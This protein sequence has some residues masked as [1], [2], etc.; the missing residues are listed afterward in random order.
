M[1]L[2]SI[3]QMAFNEEI[4]LD[5]SEVLEATYAAPCVTFTPV[6]SDDEWPAEYQTWDGISNSVGNRPPT[7]GLLS[8]EN[9]TDSGSRVVGTE[10][11]GKER[12]ESLGENHPKV[13]GQ[14]G[15]ERH[16]E[17][18]EKE[19][20][21]ERS[22][23]VSSGKKVEEK[24]MKGAEREDNRWT[25]TVNKNE[26][27]AARRKEGMNS[28]RKGRESEENKK[29]DRSGAKRK[30]EREESE[31]D[32]ERKGL[33]VEKE[34]GAP[35][36]TREVS[37]RP[38]RTNTAPT[39][40]PDP[41]EEVTTRKHNRTKVTS[42]R[43]KRTGKGKAECSS[44]RSKNGMTADQSPSDR[45]GPLRLK[46]INIKD[47]KKKTTAS[48][49]V[50]RPSVVV[51]LR[52][53]E[54]L[55]VLPSRKVGG[56][57]EEDKTTASSKRGGDKTHEEGV[58]AASK[59][60]EEETEFIILDEL[61]SDSDTGEKDEDNNRGT[62]DGPDIAESGSEGENAVEEESHRAASGPGTEEEQKTEVRTETREEQEQELC[63]LVREKE[64]D[65][66]PARREETEK[67]REGVWPMKSGPA[68]QSQDV[69]TE[70]TGTDQSG[71]GENQ[72]KG[73]LA[74]SGA[75]KEEATE[76]KKEDEKQ[77]NRQQAAQP[78]EE[79][80]RGGGA[81]S[82]EGV[83]VISSHEE[84][85]REKEI[86]KLTLDEY[87]SKYKNEDRQRPLKMSYC[88]AAPR[89]TRKWDP[90]GATVPA[91]SSSPPRHSS[92]GE[93]RDVGEKKSE[94]THG[95]SRR[96]G[97]L[98]PGLA[99]ASKSVPGPSRDG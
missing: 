15:A 11:G 63:H 70:K 17:R 10:S 85:G 22:S 87:K 42:G 59:A 86:K 33:R 84:V 47:E 99:A 50:G 72:T 23:S 27:T 62:L 1:T 28:E 25:R 46:A 74:E 12:E 29:R 77:S 79:Q 45:P 34:K 40:L 2:S 14:E 88:L 35:R 71:G 66:A 93:P 69:N 97:G 92:S 43:C 7:Q 95:L 24:K 52:L 90:E 30:H 44:D 60:R 4:E 16:K 56:T 38:S 39:P 26:H 96:G 65:E 57:G 18:K 75:E 61:S 6:Y 13:P 68:Q 76:R 94:V 82:V 98:E 3:V 31:G 58:K 37:T 55:E 41:E 32:G 49:T 78:Q 53:P 89:D 19:G 36:S 51:E 8:D 5:Y 48:T 67:E 9:M 20:G 91:D 54:C 83:V 81:T 80:A 64:E 73:R 21:A